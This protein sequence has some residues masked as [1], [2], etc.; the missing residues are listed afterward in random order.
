MSANAFLQIGIYL[1]VLLAAAILVCIAAATEGVPEIDWSVRS[2]L[3]LLFAG[4]PG[5]ALAYWAVAVASSSLPAATTAVGLMGT[6]AVS[7]IVS[8]LM[9]GERPTISLV[10]ALVLILSGV[11]VGMSGAVQ[12]TRAKP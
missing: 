11:I 9:L 3:L 5:T 10:A 12:A 6:P 7:V 4:V 8:M 1:L 2:V